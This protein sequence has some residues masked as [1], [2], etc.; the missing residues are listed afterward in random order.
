MSSSE[1]GV[2]SSP[3][4]RAILHVGLGRGHQQRLGR[5]GQHQRITEGTLGI[6]MLASRHDRRMIGRPRHD[7]FLELVE[8]RARRAEHRHHQRHVIGPD[9]AAEIHRVAMQP[10]AVGAV[11]HGLVRPQRRLG[12]DHQVL[13][14]ERLLDLRRCWI[15]WRACRASHR[16]PS[17]RACGAARVALR[18]SGYGTCRFRAARRCRRSGSHRGCRSSNSRCRR[19]RNRPPRAHTSW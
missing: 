10:R 4:R 8:R 3:Q 17:R 19:R 1:I 15:R 5:V 18:R 16:H 11:V 12:R 6:E 7:V 9:E 14:N 2:R 13:G